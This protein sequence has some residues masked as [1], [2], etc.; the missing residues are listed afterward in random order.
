[1]LVRYL[2]ELC[3]TA[4]KGSVGVISTSIPLLIQAYLNLN[5]RS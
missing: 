5:F 4:E 2:D 1:M 3:K